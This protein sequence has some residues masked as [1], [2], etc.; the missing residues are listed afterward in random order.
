M[1][2]KTASKWV[3]EWRKRREAAGN[4]SPTVG[5]AN[6]ATLGKGNWNA[7]AKREV[8]RQDVVEF[9]VS[10]LTRHYPVED[11][12]G[13]YRPIT[14]AIHVTEHRHVVTWMMGLDGVYAENFYPY[15]SLAGALRKAEMILPRREWI[16]ALPHV[17][18]ASVTLS[19]DPTHLGT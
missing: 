2:N 12:L 16:L 8:P 17:F 18:P 5:H 6:H 15:P 11:A 10:G 9:L 7:R 19:T 4:P 1:G 13:P 14:V 3:L